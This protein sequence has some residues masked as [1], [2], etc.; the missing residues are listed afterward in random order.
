MFKPGDHPDAGDLG[1]G[2][3][4]VLTVGRQAAGLGETGGVEVAVLDVLDARAGPDA[5]LAGLHV[6]LPDLVRAGHGDV[7]GR[8]PGN[9]DDVPRAAQS[10]RPGRADI[11]FGRASLRLLAGA[12]DRRRPVFV[13]RS[14]ARMAW[15]SVSAT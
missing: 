13:F 9:L 3:E 12:G 11:A 8:R 4:Q 7:E 6:E 2:D 15:F 1:V 10:T 5:D 14:T